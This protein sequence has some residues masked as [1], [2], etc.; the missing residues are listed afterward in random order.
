MTQLQWKVRI[1]FMSVIR[2]PV[3]LRPSMWRN[4]LASKYLMS[5]L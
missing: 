5:I 2:C 1:A 3:F 4:R